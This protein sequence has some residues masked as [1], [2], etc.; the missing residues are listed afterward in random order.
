MMT[1]GILIQNSLALAGL[2]KIAA[3]EFFFSGHT[4]AL[5]NCAIFLFFAFQAQ[6]ILLLRS[7]FVFLG[8]HGYQ[9]K[10]Y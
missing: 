8:V 4:L 3:D 2:I 5:S 9:K 6:R 7:C 1:F 10:F